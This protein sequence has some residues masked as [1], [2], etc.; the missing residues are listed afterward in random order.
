VDDRGYLCESSMQEK[1]WQGAGNASKSTVAGT[2]S[3][4]ASDLEDSSFA[5]ETRFVQGE[6]NQT[7]R[8]SDDYLQRRANQTTSSKVDEHGGIFASSEEDHLPRLATS[9]AVSTPMQQATAREMPTRACLA[10]TTRKRLQFLFRPAIILWMRLK[11]CLD[12]TF[13]S[14]L[15]I[16][17]SA[18]R[19][20]PQLK[21]TI[22]RLVTMRAYSDLTVRILWW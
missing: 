20:E 5:I 15:Q 17:C 2:G 11:A 21:Q 3:V 14:H 6:S 10:L 7:E 1:G 19:V 13:M 12:L 22:S 8:G 18:V 4:L 9:T 16:P